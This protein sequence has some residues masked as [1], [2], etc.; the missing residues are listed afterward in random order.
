M[1]LTHMKYLFALYL[2]FGRIHRYIQGGPPATSEY[3][4]AVIS[5]EKDKLVYTRYYLIK[6]GMSG[7]TFQS[8]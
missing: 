6:I 3:N 5:R 4:M 2:Q 1:Q 8:F 7:I